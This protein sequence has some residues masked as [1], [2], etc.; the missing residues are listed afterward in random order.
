MKNRLLL[1]LLFGYFA[2]AQ[3]PSAN[4]KQAYQEVLS[5]RL[6]P[7]KNLLKTESPQNPWRIYIENYA[8]IIQLLVSDDVTLYKQ[9][10]KQ[11]DERLNSLE[12]LPQNNPYAQLFQAEIH[13]H[14]AFVK[15]KFGHEVSACWDI[16]KAYRLLE[17]N[18]QRYPTFLPNRKCLGL[19]HVLFGSTPDQYRWVTNLLR[20]R[21]NVPQGMA[22]LQEVV[23]KDPLFGQEAQLV[24][25]LLQS[26]VVGMAEPQF[27]ALK[28]FAKKHPQNATFQLFTTSILVKNNH[29]E[30]ALYFLHHHP[31]GN[32][33]LSVPSFAYL[34]GEVLIQKMQYS[35]AVVAY[36]QFLAMSSGQN[37]KKDVHYKLFL[38]GWLSAEHREDKTLITKILN[39][40]ST[41]TEP[42]RI[43]QKFAEN[44]QKKQLPNPVLMK[45]RLGF[46]GGYYTSALLVLNTLNE[47]TL[48]PYDQAEYT[49]RKGR[50][51]HK[52]ND[53]AR[54][55]AFYEKALALSQTPKWYF[56]AAAALHL[57]YIC[58][59]QGQKAK[60]TAYFK[61]VIAYPKHEYKTSMDNKAKAA[62]NAL[63]E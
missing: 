50:I 52:T 49:Y 11:E 60:A 20:L 58:R 17:S 36:E 45:A 23:Q 26:Y 16:I 15:L 29:S 48:N 63:G 10:E 25:F 8:D 19:L 40:G 41:I 33:Y 24:S 44:Y 57:G 18:Q 62:L 56:G 6:E 28:N 59:E 42:D 2:Q 37:F 27:D 21:G 61:Q 14:W 38:C 53:I 51:L 3:E 43:A 4:M 34:L 30:D 31:E 46:D 47:S 13:L 22:E 7:G 35:Q 54:A 39:T 9:L 32:G 1:F 5:M 12:S 55:T